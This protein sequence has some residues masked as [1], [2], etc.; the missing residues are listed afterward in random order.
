MEVSDGD[1]IGKIHALF[2]QSGLSLSLAESCTGGYISH[3]LTTLPG[4]SNFFDSSIVSY[5]VESKLKLLGIRSSVAKRHGVI[6]SEMAEAMAVAVRARRGTDYSLAITGNLGPDPMEDKK[7]GLVY[8]AVDR[9][10]ET[11]SRGLIFDGSREEIKHKA[12]IAALEFL[13]EVVEVWG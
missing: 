11:V 13:R 6:S 10:G 7:V 5:S 2:I 8:V 9:E 3:L 12:A 1:L 4:A